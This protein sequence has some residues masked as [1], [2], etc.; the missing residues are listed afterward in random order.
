MKKKL[1]KIFSIF[2]IIFSIL[3]I[4]GCD[5][6]TPLQNLP[7]EEGYP[8]LNDLDT[9][10]EDIRDALQSHIDNLDAEAGFIVAGIPAVSA[11]LNSDDN[12][13]FSLESTLTDYAKYALEETLMNMT[14]SNINPYAR[15]ILKQYSIEKTFAL[16]QNIKTGIQV[17][18]TYKINWGSKDPYGEYQEVIKSAKSFLESEEYKRASTD[19][20]KI[21][22]I[23]NYLVGTFQYD[24]R[25]FSDFPKDQ[26]IY[27]A[28]EMINDNK[29]EDRPINSYPRG[30]CQA[31]A[32]YGFIMLREAGFKAISISG[33]AGDVSHIWNMVKL[34]ENWYHI[35]FTWNDPVSTGFHNGDYP[36]YSK[37]QLGAGYIMNDY[38]LVSDSY[39]E[40]H[41]HKWIPVSYNYTYPTAPKN[42]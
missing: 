31:Y 41:D 34:Q 22:K 10:K 30:V 13:R 39:M 16:G 32:E 29:K 3:F 1:L 15:S 4:G 17:K 14:G 18:L 33:T 7:N 21:E 19:K 8:I 37:I 27:S 20:E 6:N 12:Q 25:Y 2:T 28:Y 36:E 38:L 26:L 35:D 42:Y 5:L 9:L 24:Y 40:L 23:N 11:I